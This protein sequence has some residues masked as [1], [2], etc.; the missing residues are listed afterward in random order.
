MK[1]IKLEF[2]FIISVLFFLSCAKYNIDKPKKINDSN[3]VK[4]NELSKNSDKNS[5]QLNSSAQKDNIK[6]T[7]SLLKKNEKYSLTNNKTHLFNEQKYQNLEIEKNSNLGQDNSFQFKKNTFSLNTNTNED[8]KRRNINAITDKKP[9]ESKI[10]DKILRSDK[11]S[12]YPNF[13]KDKPQNYK[14]L[15][16][17]FTAKVNG[18]IVT[19]GI[20]FEID[21]LS[22]SNNVQHKYKSKT[23]EEGYFIIPIANFSD[24]LE[25]SENRSNDRWKIKGHKKPV[26]LIFPKNYYWLTNI[27]VHFSIVVNNIRSRWS[28]KQSTILPTDAENWMAIKFDR[29][30]LLEEKKFT[31]IDSKV[32]IR[33]YKFIINVDDIRDTFN[34]INT[35][36]CEDILKIFNHYSFVSDFS[37]DKNILKNINFC[38]TN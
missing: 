11:K 26:E 32:K 37:K 15:M 22:K 9:F 31:I 21:V 25:N 17:R 20:Q 30:L 18:I 34:L 27:A 8:N 33:T 7:N 12:K 19:E 1:Q 5:E 14:Y 6:V 2:F 38:I 36:T 35:G 13:L 16:G 28:M 4:I 24:V 10:I 3:H 23:D 29:T